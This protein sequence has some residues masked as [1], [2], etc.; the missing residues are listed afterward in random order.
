MNK[1]NLEE[2]VYNAIIRLILENHFRPG[3]FLL[4]T[5]IIRMLNLKSRT[6]VHH[7]LGQLVAK[8]FLEKKSKKGCY[9]PSMSP[10][11]AQQVF[12]VRENI[13]YQTAVAATLHATDEEIDRLPLVIERE[14]EI[15]KSGDIVKYSSINETFHQYIATISKNKYLQ[16]YCQHI[17]WRSNIYI[18]FYFYQFKLA[19]VDT[20]FKISPSQHLEIAEAIARRDPEEAG[21]LM[22]HHVR[23]TFQ[24]IFKINEQKGGVP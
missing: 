11:D 24:A 12:F 3:D 19:R 15:G 8:G 9:I 23:G 14:V 1:E 4:E 18:F 13:E 22:K 2:Y 7:A 5:E 17:F 21:C 10:E 20:D 6:P 16:N